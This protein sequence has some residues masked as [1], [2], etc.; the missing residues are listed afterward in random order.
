MRYK[1]LV[2]YLIKP[3]KYDD[4]GYVIRHFKGVLPSNT[5]ACLYGLSEDVR[6][7]K[8]LGEKL[9]WKIHNMDETVMRVDVKKIVRRS[10][11][12]FTKTI[13]CLV[14]V[15]SNQFPRARDLALQFR[16]AGIDVMLGGFHVS[17][18]ISMF[19]ETSSD[20]KDLSAAGVTL[21]AGEVE[22][23][24]ETL[25]KESLE[26]N[27]K[28]VY[29]FLS[30]SPDLSQAPLPK[31]PENLL[32][33]YA[34]QRFATIDCGR[35]CPF[36]CTFCTVI[37][38]QGRRMRF[39]PVDKII[40]M[41]RANYRQFRIKYYFFTDDNFSRNKNWQGIFDALIK[42]RREEKIPVKFMIQVDTQA[43]RIDGFV[44]KAAKAGC[45]Q[46]FIGV[47]SINE[48]NLE[49][50]GKKQNKVQDFKHMIET[51]HRAGIASHTAYIV[52]F[53]FDSEASVKRDIERIQTE[54]KPKQASFFM[55]TPLPGSVD[56]RV[57]VSKYARL[58]ADLSNYDTFHE[59]FRHDRMR[60]GSWQRTYE[61]AWESFYGVEN[62][63]RILR[64]TPREKYWQVMLN[65]FW[66][67]NAVQV[68]SGHPM[69]HGFVRLK[70]RTERRPGFPIQTRLQFLKQRLHDWKCMAAGW[71]KLLFQMEEAWLATRHR[72][73]LEEIVVSELEKIKEITWNW[74]SLR[75]SELQQ[76]YKKAALYLKKNS[77]SKP[78]AIRVPSRFQLWIRKWNW[79]SDSL[80][81]TRRGLTRFWKTTEIRLRKGQ[82][83]AIAWHKVIWAAGFEAVLL[84]K[85]GL[86][87]LHGFL[88]PLSLSSS[89]SSQE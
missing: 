74:Q 79:L 56:H 45:S 80:T 3:S 1:K 50:A 4:D 18:I 67:K 41:I 84:L 65:F 24:W 34:V 78:E 26:G 20:L 71:I 55:L 6:L 14:G 48:E 73:R 36:G 88:F 44:E 53:P 43:H 89:R 23:Q 39:R 11:E 69:L 87:L 61:W 82:M 59:T 46:V 22:G 9:K 86:S 77:H 29:N 5:L 63:I 70:H 15:Q 52:G 28:K 81:F 21:V 58:D 62:M 35:G 57:A 25:L 66:Y 37:N 49:A 13:I 40:D 10:R 33:S 38:V 32:H 42:L 16:E 76:F 54:L 60:G 27:L 51:Y 31:I 12:K 68:E 72:G 17:G 8:V 2:L 85:F 19:P 83:L 64:D 30:A 7:R 75:V 47:E